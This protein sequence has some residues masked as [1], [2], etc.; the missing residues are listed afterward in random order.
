MGCGASSGGDVRPPRVSGEAYRT[1]GSSSGLHQAP[2]AE[3][4]QHTG[5][6]YA[7]LYAIHMHAYVEGFLVR[8]R[9]STA[10]LLA[11]AASP[12]CRHFSAAVAVAAV[13]AAI[14]L[15]L[16]RPERPARTMALRAAPRCAGGRGAHA[17]GAGCTHKSPDSRH[18]HRQDG[19][20]APPLAALPSPVHPLPAPSKCSLCSRWRHRHRVPV[21]IPR[22]RG[23]APSVVD[24]LS[25]PCAQEPTCEHW[26]ASAHP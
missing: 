19:R 14:A 9:I 3:A 12:R 20:V 5:E 7:W 26:H 8:E 18:G 2:E 4:K 10:F 22:S 16:A 1:G 24:S 25:C 15:P 23:S 21:G 17:G 11:A 13:A 6:V